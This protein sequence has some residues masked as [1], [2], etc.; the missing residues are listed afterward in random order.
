MVFG[1]IGEERLQL[2]EDTLWSRRSLPVG[3]SRGE[4]KRL[5]EVRKLVD[6]GKYREVNRLLS[7]GVMAKPL[8]QMPYQ[9]VGSLLLKSPESPQATNYRRELNLDTAMTKVSYDVDGVSFVREAFP[10]PVDQVIAVRLSAATRAKFR[11]MRMQTPAKATTTVEGGNTL[12][13]QGTNGSAGA[14]P[15]RHSG[16]CA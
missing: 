10:G 16:A 5:P 9:T 6:E 8:G 12:V 15:R 1:G 14:F 3:E 11:S 4:G 7:T 2:N 13:L